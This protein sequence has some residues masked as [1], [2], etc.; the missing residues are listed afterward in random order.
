M[1]EVRISEQAADWLADAEPDVREGITEK[2]HSITDFPDHYLKRLSGSTLY[3]L[4]VGD[5]RVIIDWDKEAGVLR[6]RRI[7]KRDSV[8][9]R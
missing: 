9:D 4:R 7:G 8:Y 3:R 2:L 1:T 6:V 5:Y